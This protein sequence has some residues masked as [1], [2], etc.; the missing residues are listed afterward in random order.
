M[1]LGHALFRTSDEAQYENQ[2]A[3]LDG[4]FWITGSIRIDARE[5]LVAKLGISKDI[6]LNQTPD[7]E[8]VL[9]A[10][11][12]WGER[13]VNHLLGDFAF[14]IWDAHRRQLFC[15]RDRLGMRQLYYVQNK[16]SLIICNSMHVLLS[17]PDVSQQLND[18]AIGGFLLFGDHSWL[19]RSITAFADINALLPAHSLVLREGELRFDQYWDL[20]V[21]TPLLNYRDE[22]LYIDH[23]RELFSAAVADRI[24]APKVA[25][26]MSGGM[27]SSAVAAV[28][29]A[30]IADKYP[31][32]ELNAATVIHNRFYHCE[33]RW[34]A[35]LVAS[36]LQLPIH[37][38]CGDRFPFLARGVATTAPSEDVQPLLL[39][40]FQRTLA[41]LGRTVLTGTSA[42]ELF[43][44]PPA[45]VARSELGL[46]G[47]LAQLVKLKHRYGA[48]PSLG[49]GLG[50]K[51][52]ALFA[53][54]RPRQA[55]AYPYPSWLNQ[56]FEEQHQLRSQWE[57]S[58]EAEA[59]AGRSQSRYSSLKASLLLPEWANEDHLMHSDFTLSQESDP[60]TDRRLIEWVLSLPALPWLY[61]KDILR[62]SMQDQ[63]PVEVIARP[64]TPLGQIRNAALEQAVSGRLDHWGADPALERYVDRSKVPGLS[65]GAGDPAANYVNLRPLMLNDWLEQIGGK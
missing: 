40:D 17:H 28:A 43:D 8:L 23:F 11:R 33:E 27:D 56:D 9:R 12:H 4:K 46:I 34:Y 38:T 22:R 14:A 42:D 39:L 35:S 21:E 19:D 32:Y 37:Y 64:K 7:S 13:C 57:Q 36:R 65:R 52:R 47:A 55:S 2:P 29:Q 20:P 10:Y 24:R 41:S 18:R 49:T 3:C 30:V 62:R 58:W 45:A 5:E 63:L 6:S 44:Y 53:N 15:A 50:Q 16:H 25:I 54:H 48:R 61:N 26:S 31:H 59:Y 60:Y 51:F 1:G